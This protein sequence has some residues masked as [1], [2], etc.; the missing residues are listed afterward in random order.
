MYVCNVC[1]HLLGLHVEADMLVGH[2]LHEGPELVQLVAVGA[3]GHQGVPQG[4]L[5]GPGEG[6]LPLGWGPLVR[7]VEGVPQPGVLGE[8]LPVECRSNRIFVLLK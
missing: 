5:L 1:V 6:W 2:P 4:K 8:Q 7:H 3:V